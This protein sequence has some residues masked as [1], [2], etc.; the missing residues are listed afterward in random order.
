MER[1]NKRKLNGKK[2]KIREMRGGGGW[3]SRVRR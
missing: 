3:K 1:E 2:R